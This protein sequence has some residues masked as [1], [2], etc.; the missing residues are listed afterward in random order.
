[1]ANATITSLTAETSVASTDVIPFVDLSVAATR[2]ATVADI[3][4]GGGALTASSISTITGA[5]SFADTKLI[6]NGATSG[7]TTLKAT[8]VAGT[9]TATFPATTGTVALQQNTFDHNN[10][11]IQNI[12]LA[13]F[14]DI[15]DN[16]N[17]GTTDTIDWGQGN[18]QKSTLTGNVTYTFTAPSGPSRL[19]LL[20]Y[21]GAGSFSVT[22]PGTVKWPSS[23]APTITTTAAKTDIVTF[24]Y[25]GTSYYGTY[26]QNF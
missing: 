12:R 18:F 4:A 5:K 16:G 24:I 3:L 6:M 22:W 13:E 21:T 10:T 9:T 15:Y 14:Y 11:D 23:T 7:T 17:S 19:T 26:S 25:N 1:M 20:I 2:K 8:A